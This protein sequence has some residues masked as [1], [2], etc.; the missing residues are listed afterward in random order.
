[1]T[2]PPRLVGNDVVDLED[3]ANAG[4]HLRPRFVRRVLGPAEQAALAASCGPLACLWGFFAA[5][6]AAY[7]VLAKLG[8]P[9]PLAHR[10]F[11]VAADLGAVRHGEV[12]LGLRVVVEAGF[13]HAV[14]WLGGPPPESAVRALGPGEEPGAAARA[15]LLERLGAGPGVEIVRAPRPGSWDG[16]GPPRA[17]RAGAW[18]GMD[19]S[20]SRDGRQVA[21]AHG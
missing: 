21:C 3:P 10:R 14:A 4:A 9:P 19:V 17:V 5:K 6:E 8:P 18:L 1:M 16:R 15:L 11:E 20:L 7:K 13:V 2:V 12:V